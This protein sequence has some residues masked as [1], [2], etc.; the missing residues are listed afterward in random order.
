MLINDYESPHIKLK[1][2]AQQNRT[3]IAASN[4]IAGSSPQEPAIYYVNVNRACK[5]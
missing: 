5:S 3:S 2:S 1:S 4:I